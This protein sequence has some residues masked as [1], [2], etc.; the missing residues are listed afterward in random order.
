MKVFLKKVK[1]VIRRNFF[2]AV[3]I[4][5]GDTNPSDTTANFQSSSVQIILKNID[6]APLESKSEPKSFL[7]DS[8]AVC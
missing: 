4:A 1:R 7:Y 8:H 6:S 5:P 2:S 3:I